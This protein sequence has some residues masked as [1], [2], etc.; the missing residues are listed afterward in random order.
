MRQIIQS[1]FITIIVGIALGSAIGL[2][3]DQSI[4]K[5]TLLC[6]VCQFV[7]FAI[8]NNYIA[9]KNRLYMERELTKRMDAQSRQVVQV[10]CASC[11]AMNSHIISYTESNEFECDECGTHNSIYVNITTA[12]KTVPVRSESLQI[13]TIIQNELDA[14][15][16]L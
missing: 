14:R 8:Y 16:R 11:S 5:M 7:F 12:Q 3:F 2:A 10:P 15:T 9:N 1:L 4:I 13:K 6:I